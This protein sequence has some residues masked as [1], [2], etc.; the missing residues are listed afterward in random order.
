M[1]VIEIYIKDN[2]VEKISGQDAIVYVHDCDSNQTTTMLF[3]KQ[4]QIYEQ[5]K[6]YNP[7]RFSNIEENVNKK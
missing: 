4:E 2:K 7:L 6:Y 5:R 1:A 3:K